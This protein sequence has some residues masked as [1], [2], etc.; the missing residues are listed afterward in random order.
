M[1]WSTTRTIN[2]GP[3]RH[4][5]RLVLL[6]ILGWVLLY[7]LNFR[8]AADAKALQRLLHS[9]GSDHHDPSDLLPGTNND[10][11]PPRIRIAAGGPQIGQASIE[12]PS[13]DGIAVAAGELK[14]P[15]PHE[16]APAS[17]ASAP[18]EAWK[19]T[20]YTAPDE[21]IDHVVFARNDPDAAPP[22]LLIL[23]MTR[24]AHS[25]GSN[26]EP[27]NFSS[28]L[29]L[30]STSGLDLATCGL[31]IL[32]SSPEEFAI[33]EAAL[34]AD[35]EKFGSA[36]LILHPGYTEHVN[37]GGQ[38]DRLQRH[39]N[40]IQHARRVQMA[41]LRNYLMVSALPLAPAATGIL[42][43]D[44]DIFAV[45][46]GLLEDMRTGLKDDRIGVLTALSLIGDANH[47]N[48]YDLNAWRGVRSQPSEEVRETLREETSVWTADLIDGEHFS[49]IVDRLDGEDRAREQHNQK[50]LDTQATS[51]GD[52]EE[53]KLEGREDVKEQGDRDHRRRETRDSV[54][55]PQTAEFEDED[56]DEDDEK[57]ETTDPS[58]KQGDGTQPGAATDSL[59]PSPALEEVE[60]PGFFRLD[61][62]G[63]TVLMLK[64]GL[65]R[66]GLMFATSYL[67]G[68]DWRSE[69]WDGVES[70]GLC[71]TARSLGA[72]CWGIRR[73]NSRHAFG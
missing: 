4:V 50:P 62:V 42:W 68:T 64:A 47:G 2:K 58:S 72:G 24:D 13:E 45:S 49:Q 65:V 61:A 51:R 48:D 32:T 73:G 22:S 60:I 8:Q 69:G 67:V 19:K 38:L 12:I 55:D 63:A 15:I 33:Y 26:Q 27:R 39:N 71:I 1:P 46:E 6:V 29:Q 25:W 10:R 30:L 35:V 9:A 14:E 3:S 53:E 70:E 21:A 36:H 52:V 23:T 11:N 37:Q 59:P 34:D 16:P 7:N 5:L 40:N 57:N 56:E 41:R 43:M 44:S 18:K 28:F 66:Q 17:P 31:G 54:F 20:R